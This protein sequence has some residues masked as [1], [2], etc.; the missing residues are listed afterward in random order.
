M[1]KIFTIITTIIIIFTFS[2]IL[3]IN[4]IAVDAFNSIDA[5]Q[6][7]HDSHN[8]NS[9]IMAGVDYILSNDAF[10]KINSG[11]Y[12]TIF[13]EFQNLEAKSN[14]VKLSLFNDDKEIPIDSEIST[15][16]RVQN[17]NLTTGSFYAGWL[18]PH[19]ADAYQYDGMFG[20]PLT[21]YDLSDVDINKVRIYTSFW[22]AW[23][24]S[25]INI[26]SVYLG[27]VDS[28]LNN[29]TMIHHPFEDGYLSYYNGEEGTSS[30]YY[31]QSEVYSDRDK[32]DLIQ[33]EHD[34]ANYSS[35]IVGGVDYLLSADATSKINS[36]NYNT[37]F[38]EFKN[39]K[40]TANRIKLALFQDEIEIT[41]GA[42]TTIYRLQNDKLT[43]GNFYAGWLTPDGGN[44]ATYNGMFGVPLSSYDLSSSD[45][46]KIRIYTSFWA[47][48]KGSVINI[49]SV[50]LGNV[51]ED[52][53]LNDLECIHNPIVDGYSNY[54]TGEIGTEATYYKQTEIN[55][56]STYN[57]TFDSNGGTG[58]MDDIVINFNTVRLLP[59]NSYIN[60]GYKLSG[61]STEKDGI[62]K[63]SPGQAIKNLSF[64]QDENII[65]YAK[66]EI[67]DYDILYNLDGGINGNNPDSF[68]IES[69]ILLESA[70]KSGYDF[71]GWYTNS[72]FTGDA[73]SSIPLETIG[74]IELYAKFIP[75]NYTIT[76]NLDGGINGVNPTTFTI[77]DDIITIS[78]AQKPGFLFKGWYLNK[79]FSG[80]QVLEIDPIIA[81]NITLYAK[82]IEIE[83]TISFEENDG[84]EVTD[85]T[86]TKDTVVTKPTDPTR[87]G[88]IFKGWF[89]DE[90]LTNE[91][92]FSTMPEEN[93]ILYAKWEKISDDNEKNPLGLYITIGSIASLLIVSGGIY[94]FKKFH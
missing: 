70:Y 57:V 7:T 26:G 45:I 62:V 71:E 20:I 94:L 1:R 43:I 32:I 87:E 90:D 82:F 29:L 77:E 5:I 65:L 73:V 74:D 10:E 8:S 13:F 88:Y 52:N 6:I 47:G 31:D 79:D 59:D 72:N 22:N 92:E 83:Y 60:S 9:E 63:Y 48:W 56:S 68:N 86:G 16:Y 33:I 19:G 76:Y 58:S 61:W 15:I 23:M 37:V 30:D 25:K 28:S 81:S 39:L 93:I 50:Y 35:G 3:K 51:V 64:T 53:E 69:D 27:N 89:I 54:Y 18:T 75:S 12:N 55:V 4:A 46:N 41:I 40:E 85:I 14:R 66:W 80:E 49:G 34:N 84:S 78:D 42:S 38:F 2:I 24:D 17:N 21:S 67:E 36:G 91:Y 44:P 11:D